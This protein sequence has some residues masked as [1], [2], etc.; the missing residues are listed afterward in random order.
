MDGSSEKAASGIEVS[1]LEDEK[2]S[3]E[4]ELADEN[5]CSVSCKLDLTAGDGKNVADALGQCS[6]GKSESIE[7]STSVRGDLDGS[8]NPRIGKEF[9]NDEQAYDFYNAYAWKVG[10]SVRKGKL[11]RTR[12]GIIWERRFVC[13]CEGEECKKRKNTHKNWM[14]GKNGDPSYNMAFGRLLILKK[15]IITIS[16]R[17]QMCLS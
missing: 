13:S 4:H 8:G 9:D 12:K 6:K 17:C 1:N 5:D 10:F 7:G 2:I 16:K 11:E 15:V 3:K 14:F